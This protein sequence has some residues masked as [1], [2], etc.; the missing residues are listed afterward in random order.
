MKRIFALALIRL[1]SLA[2]CQEYHFKP[3]WKKGEQKKI[4]IT[5]VEEEFED[6]E[7]ISSETTYN[8][9]SIKVVKD[10]KDTYTL[11]ILMENQALK[12]A[13]ELYDKLGDEL[14]DGKDLKLLYSVNKETA[15]AELLNW[16]EAQKFMHNSIDQITAILDEKVPDIAPF[17]GMVFLPI[18]EIYKSKENIE[19]SM[20]ENIGFILTPFNK[21]FKLGEPISTTEVGDNPFNPMS[22]MSFTTN[23]TLKSVDEANKICTLQQEIEFDLSAFNQMIK[24]M[25]LKMTEAF[26]VDDSARAKQKKDLEDFKMD[27]ETKEVL[28]FNY[29]STWVNKVVNTYTISGKDPKSG[30]ETRKE[31]KTTVEVI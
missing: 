1:S 3:L 10:N 29:Q 21:D 11:E 8:D 19:A 18:K 15:E 27:I 5:Q 31:V 30:L 17:M 24:D 26:G 22:E 12:A 7:L 16:K 2:F 6:G 9:A 28:S 23:L 4:S 25:M 13:I 14:T 20:E